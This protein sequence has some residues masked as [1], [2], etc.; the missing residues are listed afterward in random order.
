MKRSCLLDI[1]SELPLQSFKN[2]AISQDIKKYLSNIF[3]C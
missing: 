3:V 2:V 1:Y